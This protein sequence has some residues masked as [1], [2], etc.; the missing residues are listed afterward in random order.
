MSRS[1]FVTRKEIA[2][3]NEVSERTI[4]RREREL[5]LDKCRDRACER[6]IRY[7]RSCA[8]DELRK[9]KMRAAD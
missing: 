7:D 2:S 6:P 8:N 5:G 1:K 4:R 9:R 3:V